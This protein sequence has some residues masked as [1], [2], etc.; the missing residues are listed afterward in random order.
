MDKRV[1][2]PGPAGLEQLHVKQNSNS[3]H[4]YTTTP[5]TVDDGNEARVQ[6][7]RDVRAAVLEQLH[8]ELNSECG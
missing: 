4:L 7:S 3:L 2:P 8:V 6:A 5:H 1:M